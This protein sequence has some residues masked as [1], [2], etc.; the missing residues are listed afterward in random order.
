[1]ETVKNNQVIVEFKNGAGNFVF[2]RPFAD[3]QIPV[4]N[5]DYN[6]LQAQKTAV[7]FPSEKLNNGGEWK[8]ST[9][10]ISEATCYFVVDN[11]DFSQII[12][13]SANYSEVSEKLTSLIGAKK[14]VALL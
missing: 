4:F 8:E 12:E 3:V 2:H 6:Y 7:T 13:S 10:C 5:P 9:S 11:N 14:E 1:M